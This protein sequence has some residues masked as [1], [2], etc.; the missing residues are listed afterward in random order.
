MSQ[1]QLH[2]GDREQAGCALARALHDLDEMNADLSDA[3]TTEKTAVSDYE[4]LMAA[5]KKEVDF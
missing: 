3:Q 2:A 4:G 1:R 5:K